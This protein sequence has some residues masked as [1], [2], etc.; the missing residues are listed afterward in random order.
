MP[1]GVGPMTRAMLLLNVVES[2][3]RALA[4]TA[5]DTGR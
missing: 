2:A 1:G 3:E 5:E 4:E